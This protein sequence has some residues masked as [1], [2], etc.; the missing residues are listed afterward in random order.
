MRS[1]LNL[2]FERHF[3]FAHAFL[4]ASGRT[5]VAGS[6]L[7]KGKVFKSGPILSRRATRSALAGPRCIV[8]ASLCEEDQ[9]LP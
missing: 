9:N 5:A 7:N 3:S 1:C 6:A 8:D 2:L 4:F